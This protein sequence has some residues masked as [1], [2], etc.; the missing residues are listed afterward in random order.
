MSDQQGGAMERGR[1]L[2]VHA[3]TAAG[4]GVGLIALERAFARDFAACFALLALALFIDGVDGTLARRAGVK[5]HAP[6]IDGDTLDNVVDFLTYVVVPAVALLQSGLAPTWALWPLAFLVASAS[7]VYFADKRM[8]T[9]DHWFRGFPALWNVLVFY[10][11]VFQPPAAVTVLVVIVAA[12]G[13]F[14]PVVFVHP[15][16]VTQMRAVTMAMLAVWTASA[17]IALVNDLTGSGLAKA[18]LA[19]SAAYFLLLPLARGTIYAQPRD[20]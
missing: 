2:A 5:R 7:A 13:M 9:S 15:V 18:G 3:F 14:T 6:F 20:R 11:L 16:R 10:L 8:K 19:L 4:A 12:A 1:A 17:A